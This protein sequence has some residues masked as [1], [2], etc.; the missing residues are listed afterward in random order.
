MSK[1]CLVDIIGLIANHNLKYNFNKIHKL[2]TES[3]FSLAVYNNL[4]NYIVWNIEINNIGDIYGLVLLCLL[5]EKINILDL[6]NFSDY[7][8]YFKRKSFCS[9]LINVLYYEKLD[10]K[11]LYIIINNFQKSKKNTLKKALDIDGF[12]CILEKEIKPLIISLNDLKF[13]DFLKPNKLFF[14]KN[15]IDKKSWEINNTEEMISRFKS[16]VK[17]FRLNFLM[18]LDINIISL[19]DFQNMKYEDR[20]EYFKD[21]Y[22]KLC[23]GI[24]K[25][26]KTYNSYH[27][28]C[29]KK[30][31][32]YELYKQLINKDKNK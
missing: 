18:F 14:E 9:R 26:F 22:R 31:Q 16:I 11:K 28:N 17:Y 1:D 25:I 13:V 7:L 19:Y 27:D 15:L 30:K 20:V 32:F 6:Y 10:E 24:E 21:T 29:I 3:K 8:E 4:F 23:F 12:L 5:L 2:I